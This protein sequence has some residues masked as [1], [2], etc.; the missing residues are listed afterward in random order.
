MFQNLSSGSSV[1]KYFELRVS[2][3]HA[4]TCLIPQPS[5]QFQRVW[6]KLSRQPVCIGLDRYVLDL[7][8]SCVTVL[9]IL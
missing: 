1:G 6:T 7:V 2:F 3:T 5:F 8:V 9:V 4:C